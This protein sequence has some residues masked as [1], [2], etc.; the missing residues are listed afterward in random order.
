MPSYINNRA[1]DALKMLFVA[2]DTDLSFRQA[3]IKMRNLNR[4]REKYVVKNIDKKYILCAIPIAVFLFW[5]AQYGYVF[6]DEPF[7]YTVAHRLSMGDA[8]LV[9]E[10][11][12]AQNIGFLLLPL[13]KVYEGVFNNLD[14][15]LLFSRFIYCACWFF[16]VSGVYFALKTY[17]KYAVVSMLYLA[18]FSPLDYMTMSYTSIGLMAIIWICIIFMRINHNSKK[19]YF[20]LLGVLWAVLVLASPYNAVLF[21]LCS[22]AFIGYAFLNKNKDNK[23][24]RKN[25]IIRWLILV[26]GIITV[27]I[28][29]VFTVFNDATLSQI[30]DSVPYLL[31]ARQYD[32]SVIARIIN[33]VIDI[34]ALSLPLST[35]AILSLIFAAISIAGKKSTASTVVLQISSFSCMVIGTAIYA[36]QLAINNYGQLN[37]QMLPAAFFGLAAFVMLKTKPIR[38]FVLFY[39]LGSIYTVLNFLGSNTG[40]MVTSMGLS[41]CGAAGIIF[42]ILAAK[43]IVAKA[44]TN[45]TI[46]IIA[47]FL[48]AVLLATQISLE[49]YIRFQRSY[50]DD[51]VS[52]L[53]EKIVQGPA[54][55]IYT[56]PQLAE[57]YNADYEALN[58]LLSKHDTQGKSFFSYYANPWLYLEADMEY[59]TFS[60]WTFEYIGADMQE[61]LQAYFDI[62]KK[63]PPDFIFIKKDDLPADVENYKCEI[64]KEYALLIKEG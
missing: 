18:L 61:R 24:I 19:L 49:V 22:A 12:L 25:I 50:W 51:G 53:S 23:I 20:Y 31:I 9:D 38:L 28:I 13:F 63:E 35:M 33:G 55:G 58:Y 62:S 17:T 11:N 64:Y 8:F 42:I 39:G 46:K 3:L 26:G 7:C 37:H 16:T 15:L 36:V 1:L 43:E 56:T 47:I 29:Y 4:F 34:A 30:I 14:G 45:K 48:V 32:I 57:Q 54:K 59:A 44:D 6:N 2:F 10:W 21:V 40:T 60:S 5:R 41:V 27:V 52:Q